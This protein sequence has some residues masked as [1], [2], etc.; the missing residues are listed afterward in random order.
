MTK[1]EETGFFDRNLL[2]DQRLIRLALDQSVL[3]LVLRQSAND[4]LL[5][6]LER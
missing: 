3:I 5:I 4:I 2:C 6:H 1:P